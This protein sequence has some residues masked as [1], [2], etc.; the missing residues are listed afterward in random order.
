[1]TVKEVIEMLEKVPDKNLIVVYDPKVGFRNKGI[2]A[3]NGMNFS[4]DD[5]LIGK[6]FVY[7]VEDTQN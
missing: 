3:H 7:L 4:I 2:E 6:G 5:A 1:M